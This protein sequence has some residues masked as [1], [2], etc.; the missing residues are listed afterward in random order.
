MKGGG[1]TPLTKNL[2]K[3]EAIDDLFSGDIIMKRQ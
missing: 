3:R 2:D 1:L